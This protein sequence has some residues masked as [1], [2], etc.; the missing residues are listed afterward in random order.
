MLNDAAGAHGF[1]IGGLP[2]LLEKITG[3]PKY[4]ENPDPD[5]YIGLGDPNVE[6][7]PYA[8]FKTSQLPALLARDGNVERL[9]G[10][11]WAVFVFA[12]WEHVI[13]PRL[14]AARGCVVNEVQASVFGDLRLIRHDILHHAGVAS[15]ALV[16]RRELL[17]W[18]DAGQPIMIRGQHIAEFMDAVPWSDLGRPA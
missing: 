15:S 17:R 11:Q 1:A 10:Q 9:L 13:R 18:F 4:P 7:R 8:L 16:R 2:L 14:A 3:A 12:E 5:L 6:M